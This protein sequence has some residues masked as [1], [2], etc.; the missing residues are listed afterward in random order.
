[1][2]SSYEPAGAGIKQRVHIVVGTPG[3]VM[4]HINRGTIKLEKLKYLV[5]DE[6]DKM[7]NMGFIEQVGE[8]IDTCLGKEPLCFFCHYG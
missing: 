2:V 7:L 8:I 3:R 1:M 5:V 4:D 6:A